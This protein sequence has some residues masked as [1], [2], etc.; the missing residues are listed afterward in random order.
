MERINIFPFLQF[1][2]INNIFFLLRSC[3]VSLLHGKTG[4][5]KKLIMKY[6]IGNI[7]QQSLKSLS[8]KHT[9]RVKYAVKLTNCVLK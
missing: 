6:G 4:R 7:F 9:K 1:T 2:V 3:I 8:M 5:I